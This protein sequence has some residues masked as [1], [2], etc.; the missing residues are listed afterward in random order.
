L[1]PDHMHEVCQEVGQAILGEVLAGKWPRGP[2]AAAQLQEPCPAAVGNLPEAAG[3]GPRHGP[4]LESCQ[5]LQR[6]LPEAARARFGTWEPQQRPLGLGSAVQ[7]PPLSLEEAL[8]MGV[9][10]G[11]PWETGHGRGQHF[12]EDP[13][14]GCSICFGEQMQMLP[15]LHTVHEV[16][17]E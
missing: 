6:A 16:C 12:W 11:G 10:A 8:A 15:C 7:G 17:L 2:F 13:I 4:G 3:A 5:G 1:G 9:M 14:E